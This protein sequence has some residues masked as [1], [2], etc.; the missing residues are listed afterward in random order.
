MTFEP[1]HEVLA[2]TVVDIAIGLLIFPNMR[3][4][5]FGVRLTVLMDFFL[6]IHMRMAERANHQVRA[7][8]GIIWDIPA[9]IRD[10]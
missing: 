7:D 5:A 3:G 10:N 4:V 6:Q 1:C 9:G 2:L 8:A